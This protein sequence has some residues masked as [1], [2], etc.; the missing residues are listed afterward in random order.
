ML[1]CKSFIINELPVT[2]LAYPRYPVFTILKTQ[3][4]REQCYNTI[5][6]CML[7][8]V[9]EIYIGYATNVKRVYCLHK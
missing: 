8:G 2:N 3:G 1:E 7:P 6:I 4:V 5:R 9:P